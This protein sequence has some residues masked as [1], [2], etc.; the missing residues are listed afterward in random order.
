[1][2]KVSI[3][4]ELDEDVWQTLDFIS[5]HSGVSRDDIISVLLVTKMLSMGVYDED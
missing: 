3:D 4:L 2:S 5:D 1:M